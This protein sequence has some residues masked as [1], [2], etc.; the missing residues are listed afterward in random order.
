MASR[1]RPCYGSWSQLLL[2]RTYQYQAIVP[3]LSPVLTSVLPWRRHL[4]VHEHYSLEMMQNYGLTIPRGEVAFTSEQAKQIAD[5]YGGSAVIK[6]QVLAGGRGKGRFDNGLQGGVQI[7][8]SSE[9]VKSLASQMLGR[10]LITKQ[11]GEEGR[12]CDKIMICEKLNIASEYYYAIV[13][14]R[15][16]MGPVMVASPFGG[17]NIEEV[18]RESPSQIFKD[19]VDITSGMQREQAVKMAQ[20][21]GF[22]EECIDEAADQMMGLYRLVVEKDVTTAEINPLVEVIENGKRRVV[23]LDAKINF[24]DN[25]EYRQEEVFKFRD[26]E[27]EDK[28]DVDAAKAGINYIGLTGSIGCLVNGAGLAMATMDIIKLYGGYPANFLDIGGGASRREVLNGFY[29]FNSDPNVNAIFVNIFG[30]II[31]CDEIAKGIIAA[32]HEIDIKAPL[33]VRLQGNRQKKAK[34]LIEASGLRMIPV[35]DFDKAAE[36]VVNVSKIA[37]LARKVNIGVDFSPL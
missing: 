29:I 11:T 32:A 10:R 22:S 19:P 28:R 2:G 23:C 7:A 30:G 35:E 27:Q 8:N 21:L 16:F 36:T 26:W 1:A 17:V 20:K 25:A 3:K 18:A 24:D 15:A 6:A 14:D 34:S 37:E 13:M 5:K 31:Q 9:E 12:P 33:V 4:S